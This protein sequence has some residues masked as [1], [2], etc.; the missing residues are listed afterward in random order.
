MNSTDHLPLI[1]TFFY[2]LFS[3]AFIQK[4]KKNGE[5]CTVS[6]D[7]QEVEK[8]M[9][10]HVKNCLLKHDLFLLTYSS[11]SLFRPLLLL[12]ILLTTD[13]CLLLS[14]LITHSCLVF[15]FCILILNSKST[16]YIRWVH[17]ST[18]VSRLSFI[19]TELWQHQTFCTQAVKNLPVGQGLHR[20]DQV[21]IR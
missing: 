9:W 16:L 19:L 17:S 5:T 20:C 12:C 11:I 2:I 10:E 3:V 14:C 15:V 4:K 8:K 1:T 7:V 6:K 18:Q 13:Y 21:N